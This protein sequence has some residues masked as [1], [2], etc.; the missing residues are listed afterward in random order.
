MLD[1]LTTVYLDV[2][3]HAAALTTEHA[4]S[5]YGV[6]VLVVDGVAYGPGD[7]VPIGD[8]AG[9]RAAALAEQVRLVLPPGEPATT[10]TAERME[11]LRRAYVSG[12][13]T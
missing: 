13:L 3:G 2:P 5:S 8:R 6:P 9:M 11:R 1:Q 7:W 12:D 10:E 4:A